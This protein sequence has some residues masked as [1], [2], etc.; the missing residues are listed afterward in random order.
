MP[1][2]SPL[3]P[4]PGSPDRGHQR[5]RLR[6]PVRERFN[7]RTKRGARV[8]NGGNAGPLGD[9]LLK[10]HVEQV[11][12]RPRRREGLDRQPNRES[13]ERRRNLTGFGH[14]KYTLDLSLLLTKGG[15]GKEGKDG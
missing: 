9:E 5:K 14:G 2:K 4:G 10:H 7:R 15:R 6:G 1:P 13:V 12:W 8:Q 3:P 11:L